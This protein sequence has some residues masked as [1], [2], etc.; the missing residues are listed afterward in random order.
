MATRGMLP[1]FRPS[2]KSQEAPARPVIR[3][4]KA[5]APPPP[6]APPSPGRRQDG[7][8]ATSTVLLPEPRSLANTVANHQQQKQKVREVGATT[9]AVRYEGETQARPLETF[10]WNPEDMARVTA[11]GRGRD[12]D[13]PSDALPSVEMPAHFD[14]HEEG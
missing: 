6:P 13:V 14:A 2:A 8:Y 10:G 12:L 1:K 5:M 3:P 9:R 7:P 11:R 4:V